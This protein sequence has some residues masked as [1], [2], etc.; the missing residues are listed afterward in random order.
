MDSEKGEH[1]NRQAGESGL[2]IDHTDLSPDALRGVIE[3]FV[4]QEGTD[5]GDREFA[6][7]DKVAQVRRQLERGD[8]RIVFDPDTGTT[9]VLVRP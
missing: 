8:A 3:A 6:L 4:L 1:G 7:E 9:Q 5:Y 2:E